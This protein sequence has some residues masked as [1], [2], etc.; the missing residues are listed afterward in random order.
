MAE[1]GHVL[2][3]PVGTIGAAT[4]GTQD[5]RGVISEPFPCSFGRVI[6]TALPEKDEASLP[7][8]AVIVDEL[9]AASRKLTAGSNRQR[10]VYA[11]SFP[12]SSNSMGESVDDSCKDESRG[13]NSEDGQGGDG[14]ETQDKLSARGEDSP[15]VNNFSHVGCRDALE[16]LRVEHAQIGDGVGA[17]CVHCRSIDSLLPHSTAQGHTLLELAL[18]RGHQELVPCLSG[19]GA[20]PSKRTSW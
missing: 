9:S 5:G 2:E 6:D 13:D 1:V 14:P 7:V 15:S 10:N 12:P 8:Q 20:C 11:T 18:P 4:V 17:A 16:Q 19:R 3:K